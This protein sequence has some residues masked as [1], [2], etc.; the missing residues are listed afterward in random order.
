M[1]SPLTIDDD[2]VRW[3]VEPQRVDDALAEQ[4]LLVLMHGYGSFEGDLISLVPRLPAE[5]LCASPR[6]PLTAPEPVQ[7]GYAWW[8]PAAGPGQPSEQEAQLAV[9]AVLDWLDRL[10][11]RATGPLGRI[12]L[13]GFS[14]GGAMVTQ[15]FRAAP[16]RFA[17]GAVLS[18]F[19][20]PYTGDGDAA[21]AQRRAPLFLGYD[22]D[23][24]IVPAERLR[25]THAFLE[26]HFDLEAHRYPGVGHGVSAEE[27]DELADFLR[28]RVL[29]A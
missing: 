28:A 24:P 20:A 18:G 7:N 2:L 16:E 27:V 4:P 23:D 22:L 15:L 6:A 5:F 9:Q 3:S 26:A 10:S 19:V 17:A 8:A 12:V 29:A 14:Q 11:A 1:T 13:V 25:A 21:L